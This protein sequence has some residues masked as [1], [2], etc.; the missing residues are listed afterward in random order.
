M[1]ETMRDEVFPVILGHSG[2][3]EA[4]GNSTYSHHMKDALFMM[5]TPRVQA[6][7]VDQLETV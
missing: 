4:E 1:L 6:N 2:G 7:V 5:P 3:G